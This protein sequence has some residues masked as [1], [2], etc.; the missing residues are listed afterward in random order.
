MNT[1]RNYF[2]LVALIL[3]IGKTVIA[4]EI[5]DTKRIADQAF[6]NRDTE[7]SLKH[8]VKLVSDH[9]DKWLYQYNLGILHLLTSD[10]AKAERDFERADSCNSRSL[11]PTYQLAD[12]HMARGDTAK[13]FGLLQEA[14][15]LDNTEISVLISLAIA[16]AALEKYDEAISYARRATKEVGISQKAQLTLAQ[17][18]YRA[19]RKSEAIETI[20][21]GIDQFPHADLLYFGYQLSLAESD[22]QRAIEYARELLRYH[23]HPKNKLELND[24]L[25]ANGVEVPDSTNHEDADKEKWFRTGKRYIYKAKW[26]I[27]SLGSLI[28]EIDKP[29]KIGGTYYYPIT[30]HVKSNPALF[31]IKVNDIYKSWVSGDLSQT[32]KFASTV[33]E[34]WWSHDES[35]VA[36]PETN[37]FEQRFVLGDGRLRYIR[38]SCPD[39]FI[40]GTALLVQAMGFVH[41]RQNGRITTQVNLDFVWTDLVFTGEK[42]TLNIM[43]SKQKAWT[44]I[45]ETRGAGVAGLSGNFKGWFSADDRTLPLQA[46]F[47]IFIGSITLKM[48][49]VEDL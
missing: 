38:H 11:W 5:Q 33:R 16:A 39:V 46:A 23:T 41:R 21:K 6:L 31:V 28:F 1:R 48:V 29:E 32:V 49:K 27:L 22:T 34:T 19:G 7:T 12:I 35:Y 17:C 3:L 37:E 2:F 47:K 15:T 44:I 14:Y 36:F 18:L 4:L 43:D 9:P 8:Y 45:G 10:T 24:F 20:N 30:Y 40:D 13:A 25:S 42:E 26:G